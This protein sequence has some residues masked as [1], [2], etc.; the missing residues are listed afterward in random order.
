MRAALRLLPPALL[1]LAI[2]GGAHLLAATEGGAG[3][4]T[5][6][7]IALYFTGAWLLSGIAGLVLS[8]LRPRS[9][10]VPKLLRDL[11]T[12]ALFV[13]AILASVATL[14]GQN[15]GGA[16]ASSGLVLAVLG[17]AIRNVVADTLSG[18]ALGF[19]APFR[20]GDWVEIE[21][22]ARGRVIEIG[23][24]TTR[25]LTRDS[26]YMILPNSQIARQR[27]TNYSAPRKEF[28]AQVEITLDH[29]LPVDAARGLLLGALR[30]AK[31]ILQEPAP[32]VRVLSYGPEG[33]RY[34]LRYWVGRFDREAE[35]RD[36]VFACVD[37]A[38]RGRGIEPPRQRMLLVRSQPALRSPS[39]PAASEAK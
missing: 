39:A 30:D 27:L 13:M 14:L 24:R 32:D 5:P 16:L 36:E 15:V 19:E 20:I 25:L 11:A 1:F 4:R 28:R 18:I 9:R 37:R 33:I 17:F 12:A 38:L 7:L 35:C 22:I 8:R 26:T 23:W 6:A 31:L 34:A 3:L 10:P 29:E 2:A 21:A